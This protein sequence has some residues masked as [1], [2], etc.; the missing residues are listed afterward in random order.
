MRNCRHVLCAA[1]TFKSPCRECFLARVENSLM[2]RILNMVLAGIKVVD[3]PLVH[4]AIE[5]ARSSS[6]PFL[7][8]HV[9][10]SWLFG[11]LI[12]EGA[13]SEPDPEIVAVSALL[14][15]LGLT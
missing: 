3:S 4:D 9:V 2:T 8:N 13:A 11:V 14:H 15:D 1:G 7:F 10:R 5:L 12:A 6:S